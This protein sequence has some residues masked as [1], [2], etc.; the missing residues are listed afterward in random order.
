MVASIHTGVRPDTNE[1]LEKAT[2][3]LQWKRVTAVQ[4]PRF[5]AGVA[6]LQLFRMQGQGMDVVATRDHRMLLA[7]VLS[8]PRRLQPQQP[9]GYHTVGQLVDSPMVWKP[10]GGASGP[11]ANTSRA[12]LRSAIN[13][14]PNYRFNIPGMRATCDHWWRQDRQLGFLRFVG[15]WLGDGYLVTNDG[16]VSIGQKKLESSA[17]LIDLMDEVFPRWWRRDVAYTVIGGVRTYSHHTYTVR[18]PPLYEWHRVMAVGPKGYNPLDPAQLRRYP[19]FAFDDKVE[20]KESASVYRQQRPTQGLWVEAEM[21][22][23]LNAGPVR[24]PCCERLCNHARGDRLFCSGHHCAPVDA[25]TRAHPACVGREDAKAFDEP[26]YCPHSECQKEEAKW[27]AAHPPSSLPRRVIASAFGDF[28]A[29]FD[30]DVSMGEAVRERHVCVVCF[31]ERG[32]DDMLVCAVCEGAWH[33]HCLHLKRAALQQGDWYCT[34][35]CR[36]RRLGAGGLRGGADVPDDAAPVVAVAAAQQMAV[37]GMVW[38]GGVFD[39]D[40]DG[41]WFY[42]KRWMGPNVAGTF[43]NLSQPQAVALLEGFCRADGLYA[44]VNFKKGS[45][46]PAGRWIATNSSF[47]LIDH[48][49]LIGQLAGASVLLSRNVQK[50]KVSKGI[51]GRP[52]TAKVDRWNLYF[53]FTTIAGVPVVTDYINQPMPAN[54][55]DQRGYYDYKD[56]GRV[57]DITVEGNHNFLTQRMAEVPFKVRRGEKKGEA[58][59]NVRAYPV[60]VGNCFFSL[61]LPRYSTQE[62]DAAQGALRHQQRIRHRHGPRGGRAGLER[63][64]EGLGRGGG[65]R[66]G[67]RRA[68]GGSGEP[69]SRR[70]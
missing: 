68:Q 44:S 32:Q 7:H 27:L 23:A 46:T 10:L 1:V 47:P 20:E 37:T 16:Y 22:A 45:S 58:A 2:Y 40:V 18:C 55:F 28:D 56:D 69:D 39:I 53:N 64:L 48:L 26:W 12:V 67:R 62:V 51:K 8:G 17:W 63:G 25:I 30:D 14:Q 4:S 50:D 38:D 31:D 6:K 43:A 33:Y 49:Q 59:L 15:F 13:R 21:L 52:I 36:R 34:D 9:V 35:R 24:R 5:R 57:Y 54:D 61:E 42:R 60:F 11:P 41:T 70:V 3:E 19:H 65:T 29:D 66:D